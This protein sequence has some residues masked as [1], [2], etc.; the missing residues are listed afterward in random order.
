MKWN[1]GAKIGMGFGLT[2]ICFLIVGIVSYYS[3][4]RASQTADWVSHTQAVIA[5]LNGL[6]HAMVDAEAG[7][8][9]FVITSKEEDLAPFNIGLAVTDGHIK[10]LRDLTQDNED[11]Q[12]RLDVLDPRVRDPQKPGLI[13]RRMERLK[14]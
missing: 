1:V 8:R 3:S 4:V 7:Q 9:G 5:E 10:R 14:Q 6:L 13:A 12:K 11:Q 2:A